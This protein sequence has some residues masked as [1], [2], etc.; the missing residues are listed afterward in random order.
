[1][2][3]A[4]HRRVTARTSGARK[5]STT[6]FPAPVSYP[7]V[8]WSARLSVH[9][10]VPR[11]A[12]LL[13]LSVGSLSPGIPGGAPE[14]NA[15][16]WI[17][18]GS[19]SERLSLEDDEGVGYGATTALGLDFTALVS[20]RT[21]WDFETGASIGFF[22]GSGDVAEGVGSELYPN[23]A[24][25]VSHNAK[26]VDAGASF[27]FDLQPVAFAQLDQ[28]GVTEG[29]ATQ[30]TVQ[31][32]ADAALALDARNSFNLGGSGRIVRFTQGS[33][34]LEPTTSI[35]MNLGWGRALST[36]M[37]SNLSLGVS[38]F[39]SERED[40]PESLS[41]SLS[42]GASHSANPRL[43]FSGSLGLSVTR[44]TQTLLGMRDTELELGALG[45]LGVDWAATPDTQ[46]SF[47]LSHGL[48]PSEFGDLQTTTAVGIGVQHA[49][50]SWTRA[51]INLLLQR[52]EA[53]GGFEEAG[54]LEDDEGGLSA[55]ISPSISFTLTPDWDLRA[56]YAL[57]IESGEDEGDS[58]AVSNQVFLTVT[59]Q[60][61]I[62]P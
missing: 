11:A 62:L 51:G 34:T 58:D 18:G 15:T 52:Q 28:T 54:T 43:S 4:D 60:F 31:F 38:R 9:L 59:R 46:F 3:G 7:S 6:T 61:D 14:A 27:A 17:I 41:L 10:S 53:G 5:R 48:T 2:L 12:T 29:D 30:M 55:A 26:Y 16:E 33:T 23:L 22:G 35:G 19:V 8:C 44:T 57:R 24:T 36:D 56:G 20:P 25:A 49:I 32:T 42:A 1:M 40:E 13:A 21:Q 39:T 45:D 37:Q 50:N 47:A